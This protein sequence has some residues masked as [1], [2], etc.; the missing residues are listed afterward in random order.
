MNN[1]NVMGKYPRSSRC[2][3][4]NVACPLLRP[5]QHIKDDVFIHSVQTFRHMLRRHFLLRVTHK[6]TPWILPYL[7]RKT[8]C[9]LRCYTLMLSIGWITFALL[10]WRIWWGPNNTGDRGSTWLRR[11][12][13]NRKVAVSIP[14]GVIGIFYWHNPSDRTMTLVS[15]HPLT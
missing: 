3:E 11:C 9:V 14:D 7:M 6:I 15:T 2:A 13:T 4:L 10:T 5:L 1:I 12:V 8:L